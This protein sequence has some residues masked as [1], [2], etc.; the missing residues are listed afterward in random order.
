MLTSPA[1]KVSVPTSDYERYELYRIL[2]I[3]RKLELGQAR[4]EEAR[5]MAGSAGPSFPPGTRSRMV[6]IWLTVNDWFLCYAHQYVSV[7][8]NATTRSDPK[9]IAVDDIVFKQGG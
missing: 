5:V 8:G 3:K 1:R 7:T 4:V 2:D 9:W 6:R